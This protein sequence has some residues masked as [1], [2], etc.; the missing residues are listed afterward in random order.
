MRSAAAVAREVDRPP[1]APSA[2][3]AAIGGSSSPA[4][5]GPVGERREVL[6][7]RAVQVQRAVAARSRGP[8]CAR[9]ASA[10][11]TEG[12]SAPT[13]RPSRRCVSGSA[14]RMPPG[15]TRP[16]RPARC[17]SS[18]VSRTS[19]RGC[20]RDRALHVQIAGAR[21]RRARSSACEI[22]GHGLDALGE[23]VVEQRE[24]RRHERVPGRRR[25]RAGRRRAPASGCS[26]SP[27]PTISV[28]VRSPT[29]TS[30]L[31]APSITSTPGPVPTSAKQRERSQSPAGVDEDDGRHDLAGDQAHAQVEL[32][33]EVVVEVEQVAVRRR[34][35][36]RRC[37]RARA[38]RATAAR[39]PCVATALSRRDGVLLATSV[40]RRRR[41]SARR[42]P[43]RDPTPRVPR[44]ERQVITITAA[45][46]GGR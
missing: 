42:S 16:Q 3:S 36:R 22:C 30:T 40:G 14:R 4:R 1:H 46:E 28:A 27:S 10:C 24:A 20:E 19:R 35:Q 13:S 5:V 17:Q 2:A 38:A 34:R 7:G 25:A 29:R 39:C 31:S 41:R 33:G 8:P 15:S 37:S 11:E 21:A 9:R 45:P 6:A 44:R 43:R 12:R 23:R 26:T 18:S 32:G